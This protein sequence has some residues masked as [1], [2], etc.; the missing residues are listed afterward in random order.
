MVQLIPLHR[1]T[2]SSLSSFKSRLVSPFWYQLS[3]VVLEK[4]PLN[5]SSSS[6]SS[7]GG[8]SRSSGISEDVCLYSDKLFPALGFGAKLPPQGQVSHE[9]FLVSTFSCLTSV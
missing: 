1:K 5:G 7:G 3:Q 4:S 8:G 2:P 9:F 6:S